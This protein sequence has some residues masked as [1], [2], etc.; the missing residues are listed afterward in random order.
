MSSQSSTRSTGKRGVEALADAKSNK[1]NTGGGGKAA[2]AKRTKEVP[3][4]VKKVTK[5]EKPKIVDSSDEEVC[6][7]PAPAKS[8]AHLPA[9]S[10]V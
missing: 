10:L 4:K 7:A 6:P 1:I 3:G 5:E 2:V 9:Y 8:P